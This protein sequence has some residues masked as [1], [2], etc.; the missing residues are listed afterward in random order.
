MYAGAPNKNEWM[1]T[2][3]FVAIASIVSAI[4][5]YQVNK[6]LEEKK[7]NLLP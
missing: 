4:V 2:L 1:K 5:T 7:L 3:L 6:Y